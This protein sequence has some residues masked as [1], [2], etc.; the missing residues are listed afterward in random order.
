MALI[1]FS[2]YTRKHVQL[3]IDALESTAST[4]DCFDNNLDVSLTLDVLNL[5]GLRINLAL[6]RASKFSIQDD[7]PRDGIRGDLDLKLCSAPGI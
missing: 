7:F 2:H 3:E 1:F 6:F 5:E 4:V